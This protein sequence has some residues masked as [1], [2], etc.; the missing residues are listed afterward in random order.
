MQGRT[1]L[2]VLS[3]YVAVR[4]SPLVPAPA[5]NAVARMLWE[6]SALGRLRLSVTVLTLNARALNLVFLRAQARTYAAICSPFL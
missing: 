5:N 1:P 3:F 6:L 2:S 4:P